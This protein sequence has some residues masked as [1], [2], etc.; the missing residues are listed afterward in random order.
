MIKSKLISTGAA[1]SVVEGLPSDPLQSVGTALVI[2]ATSNGSTS[3]TTNASAN[4]TPA[5]GNQDN[6]TLGNNP[7]QRNDI[8][9]YTGQAGNGKTVLR[10]IYKDAQGNLLDAVIKSKQNA[11]VAFLCGRET[12][13]PDSNRRFNQKLDV[14]AF[15]LRST[16]CTILNLLD[17]IDFNQSG[18]V[19][20]KLVRKRIGMA[21]RS[22]IANVPAP[23]RKSLLDRLEA[24]ER[25]KRKAK[26]DIDDNGNVTV[27]PYDSN[28]PS[29]SDFEQARSAM[30]PTLTGNDSIDSEAEFVVID[31][32]LETALKEDNVDIDSIIPIID[33]I[34]NPSVKRKVILARLPSA[35]LFGRYYFIKYAVDELS[36]DQ[37]IRYYPLI[38]TD[39]V[40][41]YQLPRPVDTN[42]LSEY[43]QTLIDVLDYVNPRWMVVS[44]GGTDVSDLRLFVSAS[45]D[46]IRVFK[47]TDYKTQAILAEGKKPLP[48]KRVFKVKG[49]TFK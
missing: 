44:S 34:T 41:Y 1:D 40:K 42:K 15:F 43:A 20:K 7:A 16:G 30:D 8:N 48:I 22:S 38:T 12:A 11:W 18:K 49:T 5:G 2:A 46:A 9:P 10:D 4:T 31:T 13:S 29:P 45:K 35:A 6:R 24:L 47:L 33:R 21:F 17:F 32:L 25:S 23:V 28:E 27:I 14:L 36:R 37:V 26:T 39:I 3:S 19:D